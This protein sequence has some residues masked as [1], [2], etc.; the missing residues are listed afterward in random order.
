MR[1]KRETN[2]PRHKEVMVTPLSTQERHTILHMVQ[3]HVTNL[4]NKG[5]QLFEHKQIFTETK[6]DHTFSVMSPPPPL[7]YHGS[8]GG[9]LSYGCI[10]MHRR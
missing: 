10:S 3:P 8:G 7:R 6:R 1:E 9:G 4:D 2:N 5:T